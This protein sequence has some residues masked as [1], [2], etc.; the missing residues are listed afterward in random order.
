LYDENI[1][2]DVKVE[3]FKDEKATLTI[4]EHISGQWKPVSFSHEY[5]REDH[6][7]LKFHVDV[8]AGGEV[9]IDM[10]YRLQ[11]VFNVSQWR[12]YNTVRD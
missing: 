5:E 7:T 1:H 12:R 2:E 3:N 11:N 8:P 10:Q 6:S 4:V 9:N